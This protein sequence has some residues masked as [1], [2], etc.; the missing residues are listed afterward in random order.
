MRAAG[1][2]IKAV[3]SGAAAA[4]GPPALNGKETPGGYPPF[5]AGDLLPAAAAGG[6][7]AFESIFSS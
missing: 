7:S 4:E 2:K 6:G 3:A 5:P 1:R